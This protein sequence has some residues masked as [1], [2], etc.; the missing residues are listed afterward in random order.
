MKTQLKAPIGRIAASL[1]AATILA[2]TASTLGFSAAPAHAEGVPAETTVVAGPFTVVASVAHV[3]GDAWRF[4]YA[5]TNDSV[6]S[7]YSGIPSWQYAW[8]NG[9]DH[10]GLGGLTLGTGTGVSFSDVQLPAPSHA[11]GV[12]DGTTLHY[13]FWDWNTWLAD[14]SQY[15]QL[16]AHEPMAI[17]PAGQTVTFSFVASPVY[18]GTGT[19]KLA[20]YWFGDALRHPSDSTQWFTYYEPTLPVPVQ[21]AAPVQSLS[22]L[23]ASAIAAG[24]LTG[25]GPN[26]RAAAGKLHAFQSMIAEAEA[27]A[28]AGDTAGACTILDSA[29]AHAD[30][31]AQPPDF[32]SGA[33][34]AEIAAAISAEEARLGCSK[35]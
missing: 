11:G 29:Y 32:V 33:A 18:P 28:A 31:E 8:A 9:V 34:I 6:V 1:R 26:E 2:L 7:D 5:V 4:T 13:G 19:V 25:Q 3:S 22:D 16:W 23:V 10:S 30:G 24:T 20:A 35:R 27:A 14:S 21:V 17:Y 15:G 12:S